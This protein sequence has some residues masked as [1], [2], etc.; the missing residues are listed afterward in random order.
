V[1]VCERIKIL[2]ISLLFAFS[3]FCLRRL[4]VWRTS[5][6]ACQFDVTRLRRTNRISLSRSLR[7]LC[8]LSLSLS[9]THTLSLS[10]PLSLSSLSS[11]LSLPLLSL[12]LSVCVCVCVWCVCVC[13]CGVCVCV[14]VRAYISNGNRR[15]IAFDVD[16]SVA[17]RSVF[18][19]LQS[20][21]T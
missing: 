14:C 18:E 9:H 1:C 6:A 7:S 10:S 5:A 19:G 2:D 21:R 15:H 16:L 11:V 3:D 8:S 13:V 17:Q 12:S 20:S 4:C